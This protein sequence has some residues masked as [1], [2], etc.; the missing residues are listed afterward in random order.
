MRIPECSVKDIFAHSGLN[1]CDR[2]RDRKGIHNEG[3]SKLRH[4]M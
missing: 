4:K 1:V 2:D 3:N